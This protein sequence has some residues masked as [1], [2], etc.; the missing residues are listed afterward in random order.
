MKEVNQNILLHHKVCK[1]SLR[2]GT[3][4]FSILRHP[5]RTP[6]L[7]LGGGEIRSFHYRW[8]HQS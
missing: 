8:L 1:F 5:P 3:L 7:Q 2:P 6:V 4:H